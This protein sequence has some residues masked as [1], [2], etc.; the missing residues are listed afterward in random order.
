MK[1]TKCSRCDVMVMSYPYRAATVC[2]NSCRHAVQ[3]ANGKRRT[4]G[5][6][7]PAGT[8]KVRK[9][10]TASYRMV[11]RPEHPDAPKNGWMMEHRLIMEGVLGRR[12]TPSE[13]VHH[14][15]HNSLNNDPANLMLCESRGAHLAEHHASE[16]GLVSASRRPTCTTCGART[17]HG[18]SVCWPCEAK[19]GTCNECGRDG[20]KLAKTA[21]CHGCYKKQRKARAAA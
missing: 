3:S 15:D 1:P 12:L 14:V 8:V 6:A 7:P 10:R 20:R 13:V 21:L 2:C 9:F 4:E 11:Y 16:A 19:S 18:R 5:Q 17:E